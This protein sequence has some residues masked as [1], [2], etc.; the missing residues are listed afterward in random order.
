M[1]E[2]GDNAPLGVAR[3]QAPSLDNN[4]RVPS[5]HILSPIRHYIAA[6]FSPVQMKKSRR[7]RC[8]LE[9]SNNRRRAEH[10]RLVLAMEEWMPCW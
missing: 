10:Q 6:P 8:H 7:L 4:P 3:L 9:I 2:K 1:Q 5:A